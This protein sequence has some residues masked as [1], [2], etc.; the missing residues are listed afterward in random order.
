MATNE[1]NKSIEK[2]IDNLTE[3]HNKI[4]RNLK[5][6]EKISD[7]RVLYPDFEENI[8]VRID[9]T[10]SHLQSYYTGWE[11]IFT[12][13]LNLVDREKIE[14]TASW[15]QILLNKMAK[16]LENIRSAV[17]SPENLH[18]LTELKKFRHFV[19]SNYT[20]KLDPDQ[21][22]KNAKN[23]L[24]IPHQSMISEIEEFTASLKPEKLTKKRTQ[25]EQKDKNH[26]NRQLFLNYKKQA[27]GILPQTLDEFTP[28]E[29]ESLDRKIAQR[30]AAEFPQQNK[31]A[32]NKI[33]QV[34]SQ[35]DRA[36]FLKRSQGKEAVLN[37][38]QSIVT[39]SSDKQDITPKDYRQKYLEY[40]ALAGIKKSDNPGYFTKIKHQE[41]E[42]I[43]IAKLI[44]QQ[45][46]QPEQNTAIAEAKKIIAHSERAIKLKTNGEELNPEK[47]IQ[48]IIK[49]S[50]SQPKKYQD[51]EIKIE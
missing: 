25:I 28:E 6:I 23:H 36:I 44:L 15:H 30:I 34:I 3:T 42:D 4:A 12:K 2:E 20:T 47:Y 37:Y 24:L 26:T 14:K 1:I 27:I 29:N 13:I 19:R 40:K 21:V 49:S 22:V 48:Q 50:I 32:I 11:N 18:H 46:P 8:E 35:S 10:S 16:P 7:N 17:I 9:S 31:R 41:I 5:S 33:R 39:R 45:D 43:A 51:K 38:L